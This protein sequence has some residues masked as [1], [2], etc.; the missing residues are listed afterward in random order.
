MRDEDDLQPLHASEVDT[1]RKT[2]MAF[3]AVLVIVL[4]VAAVV[5]YTQLT[6]SG[7]IDDFTWPN[8][9][10]IPADKLTLGDA[11]KLDFDSML[12]GTEGGV[13]KIAH[14]P[15]II[16]TGRMWSTPEEGLSNSRG[17]LLDMAKCMSATDC[18]AQHLEELAN[19][20]LPQAGTA[21]GGEGHAGSG[22]AQSGPC[23]YAPRTLDRD[24][25]LA[26]GLLA[27]VLASI[28]ECRDTAI[29]LFHQF[30]DLVSQPGAHL[31]R[32][33]RELFALYADFQLAKLNDSMTPKDNAP[34]FLKDMTDIV[35]RIN[36][37]TSLAKAYGLLQDDA[38]HGLSMAEIRAEYMLAQARET[39]RDVGPERLG[40]RM[41]GLFAD[42][43]QLESPGTPMS[44][45]HAQLQFVW[46]LL[47]LRAGPDAHVR[48]EF[49]GGSETCL[50]TLH[51]RTDLP[52]SL[53]CG[54]QIRLDLRSGIWNLQRCE[55]GSGG[56]TQ[57]S[58]N[59]MRGLARSPAIW[60]QA[61][62]TYET[63]PRGDR[64][65]K[66]ARY[67][68]AYAAPSG[69]VDAFT[70]LAHEHPDRLALWLLLCVAPVVLTVYLLWAVR[71][72]ED[73]I[74]MLPPPF[75]LD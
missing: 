64:H 60:R 8:D 69:I 43:V 41:K 12:L 59:Y 28:Q 14:L 31:Q 4:A 27:A 58:R 29:P 39:G 51:D 34:K 5:S 45:G 67:L 35:Q 66:L 18:T 62:A 42:D 46:C 10:K 16:P 38:P 70:W 1:E 53:K 72:H 9:V 3:G 68:A 37:S 61:L 74:R 56:D 21:A 17:P 36:S 50:Q 54:V 6:A 65:D 33:S 26:V 2:I 23:Q 63:L 30:E 48:P 40:A 22:D 25:H 47:A 19:S 75:E 13:P 49:A 73:I 32:E 7:T 11:E 71:R 55:T 57:N 44:R 20:A 24:Q 15:P 52:Q